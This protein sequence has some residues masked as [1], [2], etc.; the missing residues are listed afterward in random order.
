MVHGELDGRAGATPTTRAA[1][2]RPAI[3]GRA[4]QGAR[5]RPESS[6]VHR[7][8]ADR[9]AGVQPDLGH[10]GQRLRGEVQAHD[11]AVPDRPPDRRRS[12][13]SIASCSST[14]ST[15]T[16]AARGY[17]YGINN[18]FY[19]K[20]ALTPGQPAQSR[21][22][23]D[24]E[25]SQSYYTNQRASLL[26]PARYQTR[27]DY[28]QPSQ[29]LAAVA[30]RPRACRPT[31]STRPCAPSSTASTAS[32]ARSRRRAAIRGPTACRR[33][34]AGARRRSS[35]SCSGFNDTNFLDHS[36]NGSTN[37]HTRDNR[38]GGIYSFNYD[39]LRSTMLQ[40][41]ISAFY[42]AQCCGIA[43]EYQTYNFNG[44]VDLADPVRPPLLPVVHAGRPRELLAVQ[45]RDERRAAVAARRARV[46]RDSCH[47][48]GRVR[49]QP[50]ARP[51]GG[52]TAP[53]SSP[54]IGPAG[55]PP[56]ETPRTALG[57]RRSAR[58]RRGRSGDRPA[59]AVG[60]VSLRR[61]R[62]RRAL[63]GHDRVDASPSTCAARITCSQALERVG[64]RRPRAGPELGAGLRERRRSAHRRRIRSFPAS[65]YGVEQARA[66]DAR[67]H[68]RTGRWASRLRARSTISARGRIRTSSR[69]A[70]PG[71][72]PTSRRG[73]GSRR[74]RSAT[75]TRAAT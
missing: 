46:E 38:V 27:P 54:G 22:I 7:P 17:S 66:G 67:V 6:G 42:N 47:R 59:A 34:P 64:A 13:T 41:R 1:T 39:V 60:G 19:A 12:T 11:R 56:R 23:F 20:R 10:A 49:R 55:R 21:E 2:S 43:F 29:F 48:R 73:A 8:G 28:T 71:A 58:S 51:A 50:P 69:R 63:V 40:Q 24:V 15:R 35:R 65:P 30:E 36:I 44:R 68:G 18:R 16:S 72:S 32:C 62:A 9:R 33:R 74:S 31:T 5:R 61:R 3:R 57:G 53:T 37:V 26:R 4:D 75:S 25:L 70:S 14:A 45:R 52:A